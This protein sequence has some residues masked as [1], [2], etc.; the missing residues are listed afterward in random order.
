MPSSQPASLTPPS[1]LPHPSSVLCPLHLPS[2]NRPP[3]AFLLR[4]AADLEALWE[5]VSR[6]RQ[7]RH[8]RVAEVHGAAIRVRTGAL[9][10]A[11]RGCCPGRAALLPRAGGALASPDSPS[12]HPPTRSLQGGLL[13]LC[14]ELLPKGSLA[15]ALRAPD[16]RRTMRWST[17]CAWRRRVGA[18]L[19]GGAAACLVGMLYWLPVRPC[20]LPPTGPRRACRPAR[21]PGC[22]GYQVAADVAE[23]LAYLHTQLRL[24]HG[25]IKARCAGGLGWA[26]LHMEAARAGAG[27]M[28]CLGC[29]RRRK[30]GVALQRTAALTHPTISHPLWPLQQRAAVGGWAGHPG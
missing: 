13:L 4:P 23:G 27:T 3:Q 2:L 24:G 8:P 7:C 25:N 12:L 19:P 16:R 26:G 20:L 30:R 10:A 21:L 5:G 29:K 28:G 9:A 11:C 1:P 18:R 22:R 15:D 14:T 17:G 6:L